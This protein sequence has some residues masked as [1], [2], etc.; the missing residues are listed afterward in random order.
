LT[1]GK[2][3]KIY[4]QI[5]SG[6]IMSSWHWL[7][8]NF[9]PGTDG[10]LY[11]APLTVRALEVVDDAMPGFA[12]QMV[13]RLERIGGKEKDLSHYEQIVQ[14]LAE[15][16]VIHHL[17]A[18]DWPAGTTFAHEPTS[19]KSKKNP[20]I[21]IA[22]PAAGSL[23]IEVKCPDLSAY[24]SIRSGSSWQ[25]TARSEIDPKSLEGGVVL[26]K[27]NPV[28]DF[29]VSANEKFAGFR[30]ADRDFQSML[31]IV[32]DDFIN[33]PISALK[34]PS[35]GLLTPNSFYRDRTGAP[36]AYPNVDAVLV[37]RHQ[38]QLRLGMANR[39][40]A[41]ERRHFLDYGLP[42]AFPPHALI[43]NPSG[44]ALGEFWGRVL[45]GWALEELGGMAEYRPSEVVL[46][47]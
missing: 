42:G 38:H 39:P 22:V 31:V 11:F 3:E 35:S 26:P 33:E 45:G 29:L 21:G 13:S 43:A 16:L 25:L 40:A 9:S 4:E 10:A 32:W 19:G 36:V 20:E 2:A 41:D 18:S 24:R 30:S 14:W 27:D 12:A 28:K 23:G 17:A 46:W 6:Q 47:T 5:R 44:R 7:Q 8:Y 1:S 34:A 37:M 15:L